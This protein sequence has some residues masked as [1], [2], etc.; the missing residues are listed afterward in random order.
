MPSFAEW[1]DLLGRTWTEWN[2]DQAP[3]LGASLAY[4]TL[5]SLA[6]L[7]ILLIALAGLV[8]GEE[9][10]RGQLL[11]QVQ[12]LVGSEG[13]KAVQEMVK[14]A[15]KPGSG[16]IASIIG[17]AVLVFGAS[18]VA[19]ELKTSL[20]QIWD[21]DT[22]SSDASMKD[23]VK[24]LV[25]QRSKALTVVLGCGFLLLA[26]LAVSSVLAAAGTY[27]GN[28]LPMPEA[29]L[30]AMD[31]GLSI[32]VITG[33]FSFMFR[34]LP[35]I[36]IE[37]RDV[38]PGALFTSILFAIGKLAIGLYLGKASLGSSYGAAGS[39]VVLLVWVYYSSQIVFFGAEFTQVYAESHGSDPRGRRRAPASAQPAGSLP[40]V[41]A[42][43]NAGLQS[44]SEEKAAGVFG[45]LVGSAL[46][47]T[48]IVRGFRR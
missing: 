48:R 3:R 35:D 7:L 14:N 36:H 10:A 17:F 42:H 34:Y 8:F 20:N 46:A 41:T 18:T 37:W 40:E 38:F 24:E 26:S 25:K 32:L 31:I 21:V 4:Y 47:A 22:T 2:E 45:T 30:Q 16:I 15:S 9:A 12:G 28:L 11:A 13:G 44:A 27:I 43:G 33:V 5:L 23:T 29:V 19:N 6:P 39:L 1:K